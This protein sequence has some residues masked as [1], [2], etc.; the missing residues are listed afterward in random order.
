[1]LTKEKVKTKNKSIII[2]I[3]CMLL[4]LLT[5]CSENAIKTPDVV[6]VKGKMI[7]YI[8]E[9]KDIE[10][11]LGEGTPI[12][13]MFKNGYDYGNYINVLYDEEENTR[14]IDVVS[15]KID[16]IN[17]IKV[18]DNISKVNKKYKSIEEQSSTYSV[19]FKGNEVIDSKTITDKDDII[20][21]SYHTD[22]NER[23]DS[24]RIYD[25]EFAKYMK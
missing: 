15:D 12:K 23:I 18:G 2:M 21:I 1:M 14:Y 20:W 11:E 6:K 22:D 4:F 9:K 10:N 5:S 7:N 25:S 8:S 19:A 13:V 24:I 17:N 3:S 16:T